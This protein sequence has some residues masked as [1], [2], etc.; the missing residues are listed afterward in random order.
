[1]KHV[2]TM[3]SGLTV[4]GLSMYSTYLT[5]GAMGLA[6]LVASYAVSIVY[7]SGNKAGN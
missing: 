1:M 3:L 7:A 6:T 4:L 2:I 5:F